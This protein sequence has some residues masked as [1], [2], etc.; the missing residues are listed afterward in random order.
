MLRRMP[1]NAS[2]TV[3]DLLHDAIERLVRVPSSP[4][5]DAEELLSRTLGVG[6]GDLRLMAARPV[7]AAHRD[8][9]EARLARRLAGEPVQYITG[10]AA[11]RD[12]DLA[13][14]GR[15][16]IPRPETEGLVEAVLDVLA[17]ERARWEQP[18]VLDLGTGSGAI[19]I[20]IAQEWPAAIVRATDASEGALQVARANAESH[21]QGE[22]VSFAHGHWLGAVGSDE[23]YEVIVSNPPY[24]SPAESDA[25]PADVRDWE[26]HSALFSEEDGLADLREIV[27]EAPRHLV[28]GGLL[29][30]ELSES[31][32]TQVAAW[33]DGAHDWARVELRDDLAG[34]PRMLLARREAGPAI[35]PAQWGEER[36]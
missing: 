5:S 25:L 13:V 21:G 4:R 34:L 7:E 24:I 8:T 9:F 6:R 23:R 18:R 27:E 30:L 20:A 11:F 16:L 28:A 1:P 15:V 22:R 35:A 33:M 10:F 3:A 31:R 17:A 26:P 19:A 14:D 2:Q 29:A 12:L 36:R 32:A